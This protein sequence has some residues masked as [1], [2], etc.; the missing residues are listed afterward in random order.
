ML[1][2]LGFLLWPSKP[3]VSVAR[4]R[5]SHVSVIARPVVAVNISA[6]FKVRVR[7]LDLFALDYRPRERD[8][9]IGSSGGRPT[10]SF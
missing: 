10:A 7:N 5:L 3:D 8:R 9:W 4:L 1:L 2:A 6:A